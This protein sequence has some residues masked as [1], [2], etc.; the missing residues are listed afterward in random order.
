MTRSWKFNRAMPT[1]FVGDLEKALE[2]YTTLGFEEKW[3]YPD[4]PDPENAEGHRYTHAG[5]ERDAVEFM[6]SEEDH[7][8]ED[9]CHRC[10]VYLFVSDVDA[11]H[12]DLKTKLG[13]AVSDLFDAD[14]G[15]R[16]FSV[17]DPWGNDLS[18]GQAME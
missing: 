13:D 6:L 17:R 5:I 10:S 7:S 12:G 3:R 8:D 2:F 18:I 14:Y 16:D 4:P 15:M 11:C 1:Y 9:S